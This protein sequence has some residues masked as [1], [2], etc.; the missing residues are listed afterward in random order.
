MGTMHAI[1]IDAVLES[2]V[3]QVVSLGGPTCADP[4]DDELKV[5][6]ELLNRLKE[7][8]A[9]RADDVA[10]C[11]F[12]RVIVADQLRAILKAR[13]R[14]DSVFGR[15]LFGEPAWDIL[16]ELYLAQLTRKKISIKAACI[17]SAV[18]MTTALRWIARLQNEGLILRIGD[19]ADR[20]RS[21]L[22]LTE[23]GS[24]AMHE[25]FEGAKTMWGLRE[26]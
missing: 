19:V 4:V 3:V 6:E 12:G 20:R 11:G 8:R 26:A 17:A 21:W 2:K 13:R 18:A 5:L 23:Q 7:K 22:I 9:S 25:Y 15:H 16:L 24:E 1:W 10:P 14:R